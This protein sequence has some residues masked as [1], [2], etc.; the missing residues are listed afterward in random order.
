MAIVRHQ[1]D[2][3]WQMILPEI[4]EGK[5]RWRTQQFDRS[6]FS[7]HSVY[8]SCTLAIA[9]AVTDGYYQR[10]DGAL[11]RLQDTPSFQ[12]GNFVSDLV[13]R[14]NR[15]QLTRDHADR[16]LLEYDLQPPGVAALLTDPPASASGKPRPR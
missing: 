16:L 11:E 3:R 14:I 12:R 13:A 9:A 10:D 8:D 5:D 7:G 1:E 6:G 2:N 15:Q 4:S